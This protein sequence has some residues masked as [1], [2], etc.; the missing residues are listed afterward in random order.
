MAEDHDLK[1][2][3]VWLSQNMPE[4]LSNASLLRL[5]NGIPQC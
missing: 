3:W 4:P 2:K 5:L 1:D